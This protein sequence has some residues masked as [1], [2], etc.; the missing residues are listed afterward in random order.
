MCLGFPEP[1]KK[2]MFVRKD[3]E[4]IVRNVKMHVFQVSVP[5]IRKK[6]SGLK[7]LWLLGFGVKGS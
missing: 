5:L 6:S 7:V 4:L 1:P 3:K 2:L